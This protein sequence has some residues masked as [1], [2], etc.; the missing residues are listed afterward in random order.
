MP[1]RVLVVD[2]YPDTRQSLRLLLR[3]WGHHAREA[4]DGPQALHEAEAFRPDVVVLDIAMPGMDGYEVARQLQRLPSDC[5]PL[6]VALT[7]HTR[8]EDV[9]AAL[10]AGLDHFLAKPCEPGQLDFLLRAY[11]RDRQRLVADGAV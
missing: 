4:P 7:G 3:S 1:L 8:S 5:R 9:E 10:E 11:E 2:D 6:L